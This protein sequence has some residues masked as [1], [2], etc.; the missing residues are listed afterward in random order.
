MNR[1]ELQ[2]NGQAYAKWAKVSIG[3]AL[4]QLAGDINVDFA[5]PA[6]GAPG[7]SLKRGDRCNV[8]AYGERL[9]PA[10]VRTMRIKQSNG[11]AKALSTT[12]DLVDCAAIHKG[13]SWKGQTLL[14]IAKDLCDPF[15]I[16]VRSDVDLG[17]AFGRFALQDSETVHEALERGAR[18]RGVIMVTAPDGALVFTRAASKPIRTVIE[19]GVNLV[20]GELVDSDE[21]RFSHYTVKS[22]SSGSDSWSGKSAAG[23]KGETDD[24]QVKRYRPL[25]VHAEQGEQGSKQLTTRALWERNVRFGKS[26]T[27]KATMVG[28]RHEQG[29][30]TQNTLVPVVD[31]YLGV[32]DN[33]LVV[34]AQLTYGNDA[35]EVV[36]LDLTRREAFDVEPL[37]PKPKKGAF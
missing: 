35:G 30:W 1:V 33:L 9:F 31:P 26:L 11:S 2:V 19:R 10:F 8:V 20:D 24:P 23:A 21:E 17:Q 18:M 3:L 15:A 32:D 28:W 36:E 25:I 7:V 37:V 13:G 34:R 6:S 29:L 14:Q 4:G 12:C 27:Y 16:A 22:Q 5:P